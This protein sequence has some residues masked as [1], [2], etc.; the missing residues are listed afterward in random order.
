MFLDVG[1]EIDGSLPK[2]ALHATYEFQAPFLCFFSA[3]PR[4]RVKTGGF[5]NRSSRVAAAGDLAA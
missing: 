3:S 2:S 1:A 4:L 5:A